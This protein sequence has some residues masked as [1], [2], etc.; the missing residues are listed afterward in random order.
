MGGDLCRSFR[1][2][3]AICYWHVKSA[4]LYAAELAGFAVVAELVDAQR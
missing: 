1:P 2:K 3:T 4:Q